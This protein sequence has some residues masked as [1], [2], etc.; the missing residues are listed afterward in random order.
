AV[1]TD[2]TAAMNGGVVTE[3]NMRTQSILLGKALNDPIRGLTALRRVGVSFTEAQQ[4]QIRVLVESGDVMG[5]QKIIL[6]ELTKEFGGAA[7]A[8][9]DPLDRLKVVV[10]NLAEEVGTFLLPV[11]EDLSTWLIEE[12]IPKIREIGASFKE[13]WLP[14]I[15]KLIDMFNK[16]VLPVLKAFGGFLAD[17]TELI[18]VVVAGIAAWT[19]AQLLLNLAMLAN[20]IGLITLGL[21]A[22]IA[23]IV[24]VVKQWDILVAG[25]REGWRRIKNFFIDG[26]LNVVNFMFEFAEAI[27]DGAEAAFGWIPKIGPKLREA[28]GNLQNFRDKTNEALSGIKDRSQK[29]RISISSN[30]GALAADVRARWTGL[31]TG[32]QVF[33][34]GGPTSD[35][36][37]ARLS[38]GEHVWTAKEVQ[39]FGGHKAMQLA[40][41]QLI[42]GYAGGGAIRSYARGG[43]IISAQTPKVDPKPFRNINDAFTDY[44]T[45]TGSF[46]AKQLHGFV[47]R[48]ILSIQQQMRLDSRAVAG[49]PSGLTFPLPRGSY[50]IGSP[51]GPRSGGFHGGQ[52]FPAPIGTPIFAIAGGRV[53]RAQS[54]TYSY[55]KH[56]F[57]A[58]AGGRQS[59]YAHMST[60][61]THL[62]AVVGP[63]SLLGRVGSTGNSTGPHLHLETWWP[64]RRNPRGLVFDKGG[65]L[66]PGISLAINNT[67]RPERILPPGGGATFTGPI[68]IHGVQNAADMVTSLQ[69]YARRNGGIRLK[70]V[71][72]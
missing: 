37:I 55:G 52:D 59:R 62:G 58:H 16:H 33:G 12:G 63:G 29:I 51:Y 31:A 41:K 17:H 69:D 4:E 23:V 39:A 8:T 9:S 15:K 43:L 53:S 56:V 28:Q 36:V 70:V 54:L 27:L 60:I 25:V 11:I 71:T 49:G 22:L 19:A 38:P 40:R 6:G 44:V 1:V 35:S 13:D 26:L 3:E 68:H 66:P 46:V 48:R 24:L 64:T 14:E 20:P 61:A 2:M 32:G 7:A 18:P 47:N 42:R 57:V 34:Q 45:R 21:A 50:R 30:A 72:P 65:I 10:G 5:A 67:G